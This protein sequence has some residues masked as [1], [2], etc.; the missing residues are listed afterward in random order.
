MKNDD[1][2]LKETIKKNFLTGVLLVSTINVVGCGA[3]TLMSSSHPDLN[4]FLG[5]FL[6][7][8]LAQ[9]IWGGIAIILALMKRSPGIASGMITAASVWIILAVGLCFGAVFGIGR[10]WK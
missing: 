2:E 10:A 9:P 6:V 4:I 3:S 5:S 1:P 8:A 7:S